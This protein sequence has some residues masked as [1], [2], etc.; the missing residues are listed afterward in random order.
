VG[1]LVIMGGM[2]KIGFLHRWLT[3]RQFRKTK[4]GVIATTHRPISFL[5]ILA[6][7][8]PDWEHFKRI[9]QNLTTNG[10][11]VAE[12]IV[13]Q[14]F[15]TSEGNYRIALRL[16]YDHWQ[17]TFAKEVADGDDATNQSHRD[18]N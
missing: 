14:A 18:L 17:Q 4:S 3:L 7:I 1:R 11:A 13:R 2:E 10:P 15:V 12:S 8:A 9:V 16:L 5:P 6:R